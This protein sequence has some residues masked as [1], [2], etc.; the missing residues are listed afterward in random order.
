MT[1]I[2]A[3]TEFPESAQEGMSEFSAAMTGFENYFDSHFSQFCSS[4]A[5]Q[6]PCEFF[7]EANDEEIT[8]QDIFASLEGL[9]RFILSHCEDGFGHN[10]EA[11]LE[12][13]KNH[14]GGEIPVVSVSEGT[15]AELCGPCSS[16]IDCGS[17]SDYFLK[18]SEETKKCVCADQWIDENGNPNDG[19]EVFRGDAALDHYQCESSS[20][21]T[22]TL[23]TISSAVTSTTLTTTTT[24]S[25]EAEFEATT[26]IVKQESLFKIMEV[27]ST[28]P[29]NW[30]K[31]PMTADKNPWNSILHSTEDMCL[32]ANLP[33][34]SESLFKTVLKSNACH[35]ERLLEIF[36]MV[37]Q[38]VAEVSVTGDFDRT[39][40]YSIYEAPCHLLDFKQTESTRQGC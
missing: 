6:V 33:A 9:I 27:S 24:T 23:S 5:T 37:V 1:V 35:N 29:S 15:K 3:E 40:L 20:T 13:L 2:L 32:F 12:E 18:C 26:E 10:W 4:M 25:T 19:C 34:C 30:Q 36:Q 22:T 11:S 8:A 38:K 7:W 31:T 21:S 14:V 16:D 39:C 28:C 17:F